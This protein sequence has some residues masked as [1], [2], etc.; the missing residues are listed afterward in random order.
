M[1]VLLAQR[2]GGCAARARFRVAMGLRRSLN[3]C[4]SDRPVHTALQY[5]YFDLTTS[6]ST[7]FTSHRCA[8]YTPT[9]APPPIPGYTSG[10]CGI[11]GSEPFCSCKEPSPPPTCSVAGGAAAAEAVGAAAAARAVDGRAAAEHADAVA[12]AFAAAAAD[13]TAVVAAGVAAAAAGAAAA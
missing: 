11:G 4:P 10:A 5:Y 7:L 1:P 9:G 2:C 12:A 3:I 13:V 6:A 8:L